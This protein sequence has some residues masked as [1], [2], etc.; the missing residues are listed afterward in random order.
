MQWQRDVDHGTG[1][2]LSGARWYTYVHMATSS[3]G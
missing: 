3:S 1:D 2:G